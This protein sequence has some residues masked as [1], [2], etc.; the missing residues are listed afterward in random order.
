MYIDFSTKHLAEASIN[1]SEAS[2]LFGMQIARKYM[3]RITIL[4]ATEKFNELYG[5]KSLRLHQLKGNR[6]GQYSISLTANYRLI[7]EKLEEDSV[8]ILDVEDYHGN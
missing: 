1:Y 4:K 3:Q 6:A 8:R 2:R 5:H 7:M